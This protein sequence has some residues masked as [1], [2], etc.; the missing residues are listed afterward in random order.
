ML[1]LLVLVILLI[2]LFIKIIKLPIKLL[3]KLLLHALVGFA[4]LFL[5]NFVGSWFGI[6]LDMNW[7]NAVVSGV[8]GVPG[9]IF[10]L[11]FKYIL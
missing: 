9:V 4:A 5:L 10:L 7:F 1:I 3:F 11:V 6:S 2:I 8:L